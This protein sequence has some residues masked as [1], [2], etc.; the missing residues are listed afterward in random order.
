MNFSV[1]L[2]AATVALACA[3][4]ALAFAQGVPGGTPE[5]VRGELVSAQGDT[6]V[7][8]A[9]DG[10]NETVKM[11]DGWTVRSTKPGTLA[12]IAPGAAI[13]IV[14]RG[15]ATNPVAVAIQV[16]APGAVP[17]LG[18]S[19]WDLIPESTMTNAV[20]EGE[21][22]GKGERGLT[23]KVDDKL[24]PMA[25]A[26]NANIGVAGSGD[27]AMLKP[28]AK[29]VVFAVKGADGSHTGRMAVVGLDGSTPPL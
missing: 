6:L 12:S 11:A 13:G 27:K 20:V 16:F 26:P 10:A 5:R 29:L 4:P 3:L 7:L 22:T 1:R 21:V 2:N 8:K 28:G 19:S 15:P 23:V 25:V 18:Q 14:S 17:K 9:P 24:V